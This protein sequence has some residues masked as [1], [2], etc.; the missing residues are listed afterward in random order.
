MRKQVIAFA[1]TALCMGSGTAFAQQRTGGTTDEKKEWPIPYEY[2]RVIFGDTVTAHEQE[3]GEPVRP[4]NPETAAIAAL[5]EE[6][7]RQQEARASERANATST[8]P[9]KLPAMPEATVWDF[10]T[11]KQGAVLQYEFI[12]S[13]ASSKR[14]L[15]V[16]SVNT[17]C[18]CTVSDVKKKILEPGEST[19]ITVQFKT[20]GYAG[21]VKQYIYVHTDDSEE[22]L[23]RFVVKANVTTQ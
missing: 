7:A 1:V 10:G 6:K 23:R 11:V 4:P 19:T 9:A 12:L 14:P 21:P 13:N 5:K 16:L 15:K 18:G 3:A 2:K 20:K 8:E 22:N 17:S